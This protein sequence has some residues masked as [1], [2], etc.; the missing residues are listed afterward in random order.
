[1]GMAALALYNFEVYY[2]SGKH[3][4]DANSLGR[5]KW[6]ESVN[7]V[8]ANRN[9]C[10]GV[11]SNI[12]HTVFQGTS[13]LHGYV[14]TSLKSAKVVPES[15]HEDNGSMTLHKWKVDQSK[16]LLYISLFSY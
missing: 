15:Y 14:E 4:I 16:N 5:I 1:M 12:G 3:N 13:I 9:L 8:V 7:E 10:I 2:T 11:D 6:P